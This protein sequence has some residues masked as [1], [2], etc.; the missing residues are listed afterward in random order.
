MQMLQTFQQTLDSREVAE[1]LSKRHS[2]LMRD[3]SQYE[4]YLSQNADLRF[5]NFFIKSEY[6]AGTGRRYSNYLITKKGCEFL[7]HKMTGQKGAVFTAR[8]IELFHQMEQGQWTELQEFMQSQRALNATM[9]KLIETLLNKA[10]VETPH[11]H[12][13]YAKEE[14]NLEELIQAQ[15][16]KSQMKMEGFPT[17]V[18]HLADTLLQQ[19]E[20]NFSYVS[21]VLHSMGYPISH[22]AVRTYYHQVLKGGNSHE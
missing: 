5:D 16:S 22:T 9:T 11:T 15:A 20:R 3:I 10:T 21:R 13:G 17:E 1:L 6:V 8:Y 18:R 12:I 7:A 4:D 14:I 2:D 19:E